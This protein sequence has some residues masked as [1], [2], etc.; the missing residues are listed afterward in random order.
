MDAPVAP[1]RVLLRQP[2][3]RRG[4][5]AVRSRAPGVFVAGLV[6]PAASDDVAVPAQ[7]GLRRHDQTQ[8]STA[9]LRDD[10]EQERDE[11][12]V[13]PAHVRPRVDLA[14]QHRELVT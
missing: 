14:L 1:A 10:V 9:A 12:P 8:A 2:Q 3:H 5:V 6:C 7:D 4:D 11:G 13:S